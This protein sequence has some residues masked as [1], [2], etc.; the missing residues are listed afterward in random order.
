[1]SEFDKRRERLE[2][3]GTNEIMKKAQE[4]ASKNKLMT[5]LKMGISP[6]PDKMI[7]EIDDKE[8]FE[9][10][11]KHLEGDIK[12]NKEKLVYLMQLKTKAENKLKNL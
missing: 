6:D 9:N 4:K 11:I 7:D 3:E 5:A 1:M 12:R 10:L 8:Y 2:Q